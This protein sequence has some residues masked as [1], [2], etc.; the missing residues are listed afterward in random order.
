MT[1]DSTLGNVQGL[2]NSVAQASNL[3]NRIARD[4][5]LSTAQAQSWRD[6]LRPASFRGVTFGVLDSRVRFGRR[7]AIHLYPFRDGGWPEDLGRELK[8]INFT[9]FLVGDDVIAQRDRLIKAC[10]EPGG[11]AELVHP[12]LGRLKVDVISAETQEHWERGRVFE[13][14]FSF[15][16]SG[17]QQYPGDQAD[18]TDAVQGAANAA[19]QAAQGDF[20]TKA[21]AALTNGAAV[22]ASAVNMA[23]S[24]GRTAQR[25]VNDV[26]NLYHMVGTLAGQF[27]RFFGGNAKSKRGLPNAAPATD[28]TS[29]AAAVQTL[30]A[31]GATA[32]AAVASA[33]STLS[34]TASALSGGDKST[35]NAFS[36]AAQG[37]VASLSAACADPG[38][39]QRLLATLAGSVATS[40]TAGDAIGQAMAAMQSATADMFRRAAVVGMARA[41]ADYQPNSSDDAAA[42]RNTVTAA[43]DAE[44]TLAG[45]Q[46]ADDTYNA[47]RNLR[48]AVVKDLD[49]RGA[50]LVGLVTVTTPLPTPSLALAQRLYRDV[51]RAGELEQE[52]D[53][54]H[55]AFMPVAFKA[56]S[57]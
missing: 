48:A 7:Q 37:L 11:G 33:S 5:G 22:V 13:V 28:R 45:D 46:G 53:P 54:I 12:T 39:A 4:L 27:G 26:T 50:G 21:L 9:G 52:A 3:V 44:I 51:T 32:R 43:L 40:Q 18:T 29:T 1:I 41:A 36:A 49:A 8:H 17:K 6:R 25:L 56:L 34:T 20:L 24:W 38:D 15:I 14:S 47:L 55:P 42:L 31:S 30:V 35:V 57:Q 2:S 16:E 10:E 23:A 19:D